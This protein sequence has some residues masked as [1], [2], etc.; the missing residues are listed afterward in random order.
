MAKK[1]KQFFFIAVLLFTDS[2]SCL[3]LYINMTDCPSAVWLL[4]CGSGQS[5]PLLCDFVGPLPGFSSSFFF[6]P[7]WGYIARD[8]DCSFFRHLSCMIFVV[9]D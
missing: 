4:V 1:Y 2:L 9:G 3:H 8:S 6:V 7:V 5:P